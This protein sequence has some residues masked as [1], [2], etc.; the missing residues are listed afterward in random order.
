M[1]DRGLSGAPFTD[2]IDNIFMTK[3]YSTMERHKKMMHIFGGLAI[4]FVFA[5]CVEGKDGGITAW[6]FISLLFAF[7]FGYI[8]KWLDEHTEFTKHDEK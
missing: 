6:N 3:R 1:T 8:A 2:N 5:A 7:A 4:V